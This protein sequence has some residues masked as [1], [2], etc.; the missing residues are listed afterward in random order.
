MSRLRE[1]IWALAVGRG[2]R[3]PARH[4]AARTRGEQLLLGAAAAAA[5]LLNAFVYPYVLPGPSG[6]WEPVSALLFAVALALAGWLLLTA[7][8][9]R[10]Y[11]S[12]S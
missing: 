11:A 3:R 12:P 8:R 10:D 9:G 5:S 2:T 7:S 4:R 6:I 1:P